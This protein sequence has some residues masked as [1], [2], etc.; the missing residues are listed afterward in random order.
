MR[1]RSLN[2][3]FS[4]VFITGGSKA[5]VVSEEIQGWDLSAVNKSWVRD[6]LRGLNLY[7]DVDMKGGMQWCWQIWLLSPLT[8]YEDRGSIPKTWRMCISY[9][10][11]KKSKRATWGITDQS[12]FSPCENHRARHVGTAFPQTV[13]FTFTLDKKA[14][15]LCHFSGF[16]LPKAAQNAAV[17]SIVWVKVTIFNKLK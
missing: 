11:S 8:G 15:G 14:Q 13:L 5:P 2:S 10:S 16:L 12:E 7:K 4:S 3:F 9:P 17:V 1:L 6:Y